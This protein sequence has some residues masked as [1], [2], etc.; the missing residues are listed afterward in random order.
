MT[1]SIS[2]L[3]KRPQLPGWA[4]LHLDLYTSSW[5]EPMTNMFSSLF[6]FRRFGVADAGSI[7]TFEPPG[8]G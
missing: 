4:D 5:V 6:R 2:A 1:R 8:S 3:K 7:L